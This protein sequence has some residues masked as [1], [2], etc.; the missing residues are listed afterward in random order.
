MLLPLSEK[1]SESQ[2]A[3][4]KTFRVTGGY[5]KAGTSFLKRVTGRFFELVSDFIEASRQF[6][7]N[8]LRKKPAKKYCE[9]HKCLYK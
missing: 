7:F 4:V 9:K 1:F 5:L 2:A 6:I 3:S 8:F